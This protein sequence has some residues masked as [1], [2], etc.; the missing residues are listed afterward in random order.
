MA[1]ENLKLV[2]LTSLKDI[3]KHLEAFSKEEIKA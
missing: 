3:K 1:K 2:K